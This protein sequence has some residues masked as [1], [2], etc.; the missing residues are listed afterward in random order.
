MVWSFERS[1][2]GPDSQG[3]ISR[4]ILPQLSPSDTPRVSGCFKDTVVCSECSGLFRRTLGPIVC[5][6]LCLVSFL[7]LYVYCP[8]F[9]YHVG[10]SW[11]D[12]PLN[13]AYCK[14][15]WVCSLLNMICCQSESKVTG[16]IASWNS[17]LFARFG[18][19]DYIPQC[20]KKEIKRAKCGRPFQVI[21]T[22]NKQWFTFI[23]S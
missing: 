21:K 18:S 20:I 14:G 5:L 1:C 16:S 17:L 11:P 12:I 9:I 23:F 8:W 6:L 19:L 2:L 13:V 7:A 3:S 10:L 22:K 4:L 15:K